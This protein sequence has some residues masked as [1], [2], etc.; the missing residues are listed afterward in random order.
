MASKLYG[1]C[2]WPWSRRR[3]LAALRCCGSLPRGL[4]KAGIPVFSMDH[5]DGDGQYTVAGDDPEV[6]QVLA[7]TGQTQE[8]DVV[9]DSGADV[10]PLHFKSFGCPTRRS[11]IVMQ[12]AQGKQIMEVDTRILEVGVQTLAGDEVTIKE[13][14]LSKGAVDDRL[15]GP[16][17]ACWLAF[18]R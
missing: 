10:A 7:V 13:R 4:S 14:L 1:C 18:G 16:A 5:T 3:K 9:I 15:F 12:D 17:V 11:G 8:I 2:G 6:F